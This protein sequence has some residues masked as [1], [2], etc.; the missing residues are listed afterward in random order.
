MRDRTDEVCVCV[1]V[2]VCVCGARLGWQEEEIEDKE[3]GE[4]EGKRKGEKNSDSWMLGGKGVLEVLNLRENRWGG[5]GALFVLFF[6]FIYKQKISVLLDIALKVSGA[7][8]KGS[9]GW[10]I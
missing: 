7:K 6:F 9:R 3:I 2:Y 8:S 1:C 4:G 5:Y 10:W